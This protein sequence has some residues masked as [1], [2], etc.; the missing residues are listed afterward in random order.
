MDAEFFLAGMKQKC[1]GGR[2]VLLGDNTT[3][4]EVML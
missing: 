1:D 4:G 2:R 3:G